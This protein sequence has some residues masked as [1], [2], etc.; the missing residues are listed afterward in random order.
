MRNPLAAS[1][2]VVLAF[3]LAG[4]V[5]GDDSVRDSTYE[6]L[7]LFD[8]T[9]A[10]IHDQYV[11][12]IPINRLLDDAV[13]GTLLG[14]DPDA[15]FLKAD[16]Y[17]E[18][19]RDALATRP[20]VGLALTRR[21]D[22]VTVVTAVEGSPAERAGLRPGDRVVK[23]DGLPTDGLQLW[24]GD[25]RLRG[26]AGSTVTLSVGRDGWAEPRD[27]TLTRE[28]PRD[29]SLRARDLGDGILYLRIP[30]F[31]AETP[32]ELAASL[33]K[34]GPAQPTGIVLDLRSDPGGALPAAVELAGTFLGDGQL[35]AATESRVAARR[36]RF[37]AHAARS[38]QDAPMAV[39][40]NAGTASV[41]E[42]VAG[43]LQD[44]GRAV[45]V[46]TRTF[47]KGGRQSVFPLS[48]GSALRL[49]TARYVTPNGHPIEGKGITPDIV[50]EAPAAAGPP[51]DLRADVQLQR[52]L[53]IV[54]AVHL[55]RDHE[56]AGAH[57]AGAH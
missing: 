13:V 16:T 37:A 33:D 51:A 32:R 36:E 40:V 18:L 19:E 6:E 43:A 38:Y 4:S 39:L 57:A 11:E 48:D 52:A 42:V 45:I 28:E 31:R 55:Y 22:A 23:I 1:L 35:V 10:I 30:R 5:R 2:L 7:R 14:I 3:F 54:K 24:Q 9:V 25:E 26:A 47:G 8:E 41:A 12:D 17:R 21:G 50:I 27:L 44:W 53:E 49:N 56:A 34:L 15:A 20:G 46:G 29:P